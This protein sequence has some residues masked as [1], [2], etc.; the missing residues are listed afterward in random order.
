MPALDP[1]DRQRHRRL[2]QPWIRLRLDRITPLLDRG[3]AWASM[4]IHGRPRLTL[5]SPRGVIWQFKLGRGAWIR[6]LE[7]KAESVRDTR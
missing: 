4:P 1:A 5:V 3:W 2:E 7:T 6:R